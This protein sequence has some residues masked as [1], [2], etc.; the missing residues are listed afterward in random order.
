[1]ARVLETF[2]SKDGLVR[3]VSL[4]AKGSNFK[5]PVHKT[6]LLVANDDV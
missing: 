3:S 5:R 4:Y 2:A 1:M 6:V